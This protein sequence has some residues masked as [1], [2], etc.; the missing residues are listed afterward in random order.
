M[1]RPHL[2]IYYQ[3][4]ILEGFGKFRQVGATSKTLSRTP[5]RARA[6]FGGFGTSFRKFSEVSD[7]TKRIRVNSYHSEEKDGDPKGWSTVLVTALGSWEK[8]VP[9]GHA[10]IEKETRKGGLRC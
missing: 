6:V 2:Y 4:P 9:C 3:N 7:S 8:P 1:P 5:E 10:G